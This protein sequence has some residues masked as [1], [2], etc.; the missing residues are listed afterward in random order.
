VTGSDGAPGSSRFLGAN[1]GSVQ[2]TPG[3]ESRNCVETRVSAKGA[4]R[5]APSM[6]ST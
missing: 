6:V 2:L 5:G 4:R 3:M 1:L